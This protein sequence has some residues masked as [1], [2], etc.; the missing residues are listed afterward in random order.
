[1]TKENIFDPI[2]RI[3]LPVSP[4]NATSTSERN[5]AISPNLS[6][7]KS[8]KGMF[9]LEMSSWTL[10]AENEF[11]AKY[12]VIVSRIFESV[13]LLLIWPPIM[14]YIPHI[15]VMII[16]MIEIYETAKPIALHS[17]LCLLKNLR[18]RRN[19]S[20]ACIGPYSR[21]AIINA[22]IRGLNNSIN[23]FRKFKKVSNIFGA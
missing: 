20:M 21:Y 19:V 23:P 22:T 9:Q 5:A 10:S 3:K 12:C 14:K 13:L 18:F 2:E 8:P 7:R 6:V 15:I 4:I 1:M 17:P 11:V 16:A